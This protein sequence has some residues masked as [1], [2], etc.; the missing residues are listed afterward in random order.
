[1]SQTCIFNQ[2]SRIRAFQSHC[3]LWIFTLQMRCTSL[4]L[5]IPQQCCPPFSCFHSSHR[6]LRRSKSKTELIIFVFQISSCSSTLENIKH[7]LL[8]YQ[9]HRSESHFPFF[10]TPFLVFQILTGS[11]PFLFSYL[12]LPQFSY[13]TFLHRFLQQFSNWNQQA[14]SYVFTLIQRISE[15]GV[16]WH[17]IV[18]EGILE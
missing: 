7:Y 16:H 17:Q 3:D 12:P 6:N 4:K 18:L 13:Y 5:Q 8:T 2:A 10:P 9:S 15:L 14:T 1:M 11:I